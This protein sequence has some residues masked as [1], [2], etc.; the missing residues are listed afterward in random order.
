LFT[1]KKG[2]PERHSSKIAGHKSLETAIRGCTATPTNL[3]ATTRFDS[4][5]YFDFSNIPPFERNVFG[6]SLGGPIKKDKT[7]LF[8]N[9]EGF[10]QKLGLSDL[11][12]VPDSTSRAAAVAS[13]LRSSRIQ[14]RRN[15]D[16]FHARS[17]REEFIA[18]TSFSAL[19]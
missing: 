5:N 18:F 17:I 19:F 2:K 8:G 16:C 14:S 9:Y 15:H 3:S 6:G 4:R 7:F 1:S 10:R 11:T 13:R 12:L